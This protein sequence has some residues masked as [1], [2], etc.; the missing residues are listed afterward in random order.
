MSPT[1]ITAIDVAVIAL[2]AVTIG[3]CWR[4]NRRLAAI[5]RGRDEMK[6]VT[7]DFAQATANAELAVRGMKAAAD[8]DGQ[9]LQDK[10]RE[11]QAL[12]D[13]LNFMLGAGSDLADRLER[14]VSARH[15]SPGEAAAGETSARNDGHGEGDAAAP[16]SRAENEL[17]SALEKMR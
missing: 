14:A 15:E 7:G 3:Y 17:M 1:L 16:A 11:A 10:I 13:E 9:K 6:R 12:A 4:L 2:L 5:R 8:Q